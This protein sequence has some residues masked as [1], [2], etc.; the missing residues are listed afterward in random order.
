LALAAG[1]FVTA[2]GVTGLASLHHNDFGTAARR[3][4]RF[5]KP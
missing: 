4:R 3:V 1:L 2:L 5:L